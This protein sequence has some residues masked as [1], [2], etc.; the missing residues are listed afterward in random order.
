MVWVF[1]ARNDPFLWLTGWSFTTYNRF[2]RWIAR[3]ATAQAVAHSIGY[4]VS[5]YYTGNGDY[6]LEWAEQYW[7]CGNIATIVMT[8]GLAAHVKIFDGEYNGFIWPCVAIWSL[9]RLLRIARVV[10]VSILPRLTK[11]IRATA[12]YDKETD[13]IRFDMTA[14]FPNQKPQPGIFYYVYDLTMLRGYESHP[15]TLCSWSAG[16]SLSSTPELRNREVEDKEFRSSVSSTS[17]DAFDQK[18]TLLIRPYEG[19]TGRLR[20][21]IVA[22]VAKS[23]SCQMPLLLEGPYGEVMDLRRFS[24]VLVVAGGS[25]ITAAISQSQLV[26][27]SGNTAMQV[28]WAAKSREIV[29]GVCEQELAASAA[30]AN[31]TMDVYLT[32]DSPANIKAES[33]YTVRS[34][35]P[36]IYAAVVDARAKCRRDLAVVS[37]GPP[38]MA[39]ATR[40]AVVRALGEAGPLVEFFNETAGW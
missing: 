4:S 40:A 27:P 34:G 23:G 14:F 36:D 3:I 8:L 1:A 28:V 9:D 37:C 22:S 24:N 21:K 18:H 33:P 30:H 13:L 12:T 39:D 38:A 5:S 15:F 16:R 29:D 10:V 17:E 11:G 31:F 35:R 19:F 20:D 26:L 32:A 25:G 2:H 7:Y 6:A